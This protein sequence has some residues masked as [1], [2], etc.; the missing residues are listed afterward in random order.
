MSSNFSAAAVIA[1]AWVGYD[2]DELIPTPFEKVTVAWNPL[3]Y[4][5]ADKVTL[6]M[7]SLP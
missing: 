2:S 3:P 7:V 5:V 4:G 1:S 6:D